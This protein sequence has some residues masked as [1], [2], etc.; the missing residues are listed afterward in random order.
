MRGRI[1]M[2]AACVACFGAVTAW[3]SPE[4]AAAADEENPVVAAVR[5]KLK[6]PAR[7]FTLVVGLKVKEGMGE[8]LEAAFARASG[9][10]HKEKGCL[11]YDLNRDVE[12][13]E[14]FMLYERWKSL[15]DLEAHLKAEH[16]RT[17]LGEMQGI[18]DGAPELHV[19][20][21]AGE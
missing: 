13:P 15:A 17:L 6:D 4:A 8:K 12:H 9:P 21:P 1:G 20:L 7:P 19:L 5:A 14:R 2:L 3:V 11:A 16:T 10:T 18:G